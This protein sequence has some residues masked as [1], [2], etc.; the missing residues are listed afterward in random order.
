MPVVKRRGGWS[1]GRNGVIVPT[2]A[3]AQ[4]IGRAIKAQESK[5]K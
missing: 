3:K 2:K 4:Q 1:W 5:K